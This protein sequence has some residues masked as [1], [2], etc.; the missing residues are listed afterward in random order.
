MGVLSLLGAAGSAQ[1]EYP[2]RPIRLIIPSAAG[3]SPDEF[4]RF[5]AAEAKKWGDIIRASNIK[6]D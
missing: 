5:L 4:T 2:E 1:A 6:A 3:G